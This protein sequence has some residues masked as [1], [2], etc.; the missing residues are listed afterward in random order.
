MM[1]VGSLI[2]SLLLGIV[3]ALMRISPV[4]PL[5]WLGVGYVEF[6]RGFDVLFTFGGWNEAAYVSAEVKGGNR[7]IGCDQQRAIVVGRGHQ[8]PSGEM[9]AVAEPERASEVAPDLVGQERHPVRRRLEVV[10]R[11]RVGHGPRQVEPPRI[12]QIE[13]H[14]IVEARPPELEPEGNTIL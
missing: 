2:G 5:R 9:D 4:A 14:P 12:R 11:E 3:I 6:F 13:Q 10:Q 1:S 8:R 7:A